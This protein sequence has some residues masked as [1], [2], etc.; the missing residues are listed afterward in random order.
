MGGGM[1]AYY[2]IFGVAEPTFRCRL[3]LNIWPDEDKY[4]F[5]N[6]THQLL[7]ETWISSTSKCDTINGSKCT[8]FVYDRSVFGRTFTEDANFVCTNAVKR[9]WLATVFQI[10]A[11][12]TLINGPLSD[13]IGR[14]KMIQLLTTTLFIIPATILVF[15]QFI[16]MTINVKFGLLLVNQFVSSISA[17]GLVFLLLMEL[18]SSS[19]TSFAGNLALIAYTFGEIVAAL[20]AYGARNWLNHKW[21]NSGYIGCMLFYLYFVPE[22]PYWLF[23]KKKYAQLEVCLRNIAKINKRENTEWFQLYRQLIR[24]SSIQ[25]KTTIKPKKKNIRRILIRL[26]ISGL[27]AFVTM[28]L[29]IKISYGLGAMNKNLSPHWSIVIGAIVEGIG[30]ISAS[31]LITTRLGRKYTL[32]I[33]ALFTSLCVL[34]IPFIKENYPIVTIVISQMGKLTISGAVSA[35]WVYVPELFPTSIRGLSNSIFVF[36]GRLGAILAPIVDA[37]LGD[38]YIKLTFYIYSGITFI[39]IG[40]VTIL[41]E[42]R[43]RSFNDNNENNNRIA[44]EQSE[45]Q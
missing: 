24:D 18:T 13:K 33:F 12:S 11:C 31:F 28:L 41:P 36:T 43:N 8:D 37:A 32:M 2:Y 45:V 40:I 25:M 3:P 44:A 7:I 29:Y 23:N 16:H 10:G 30:Y 42:T 5:I 20:F 15:I 38:K 27:I 35:S 6:N 14:R 9:T 1:H 26:C 21:F 17:Y 4:Q 22:S 39:M 19:H 34:T